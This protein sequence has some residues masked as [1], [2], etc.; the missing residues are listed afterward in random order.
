MRKYKRFLIYLFTTFI[1]F[2]FTYYYISSK[3]VEV[4]DELIWIRNCLV[5]KHQYVNIEENK[6]IISGGSNTLFGMR[7]EQ[8][9]N[10]LN[11]PV[12]NL[13]VHAGL[14][15]DFIINDAKKVLKRGDVV[16]MPLEYNHFS[17]DERVTKLAF[18]YYNA[19]DKEQLN[20]INKFDRFDFSFKF[21]FQVKPFDNIQSIIK[22]IKNSIEGTPLVE[23]P[24]GYNSENL[25]KHGDQTNH[26]GVQEKALSSIGPIGIPATFSE[27]VDLRLIRD[28]NTWAKENGISLFI[29]YPN[30]IYFNEYDSPAYKEYYKSLNKYFLDNH[31]STIGKP[32]D[33]FYDK[34]YFYDTIYHLND[35]GMTVR[36][37][38]F[39]H[40]IEN[41]REIKV[42]K[43]KNLLLK[44]NK[45]PTPLKSRPK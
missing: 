3:K 13:G 10:E 30:T 38:E 26:P 17:S 6:V 1:L 32:S 2:S 39:T 37:T 23:N 8:I 43:S 33:F 15:I 12:Y 34:K 20:K 7:T 22:S 11:I 4:T 19:F 35:E 28:F 36:T 18:D 29:T 14:G 16:I 41:L 44:Q 42:L 40:M 27:T 21:A 5:K 24:I 25:N 45:I 9:S 31:I